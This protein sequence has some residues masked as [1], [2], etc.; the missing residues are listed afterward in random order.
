M[1][2]RDKFVIGFKVTNRTGAVLDPKLD[3]ADLLINGEASVMWANTHG[4][5]ARD[6]E[7]YELERKAIFRCEVVLH[8]VDR[9]QLSMEP[10]RVAPPAGEHF[11]GVGPWRHADKDSLLR[12][13]GGLDAVKLQVLLE[14]ALDD[15]CRQQESPLAEL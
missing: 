14:V 11:R 4:N 7:W 10:I 2:E 13:P 6:P 5:G 15:I 3:L 1:A 8:D 12:P 9:E